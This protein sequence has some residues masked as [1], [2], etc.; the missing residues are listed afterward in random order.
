MSY[1]QENMDIDRQ[2]REKLD[3][4]FL[5]NSQIQRCLIA[6]GTQFF[7]ATVNALLRMLP[8]AS[9][10]LLMDQSDMWNPEI[11][12]IIFKKTKS[13]ARLGYRDNPLI[14]DT[15]KAPSFELFLE[16]KDP[17]RTEDGEID[18]DNP[19]IYSPTHEVKVETDYEAL[20][21]LILSEA[22]NIGILWNLETYTE[23]R[24]T[25]PS[26]TV[27]NPTRRKQN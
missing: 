11:N 13:G 1:L 21:R 18:W 22:E 5:F 3:I 9:Y 24:R 15:R 4:K 25:N 10:E 16:S 23:I 26:K 19:R 14:W 27:K 7:P 2:Y 6:S 12:F 20:F 8:I 17:P